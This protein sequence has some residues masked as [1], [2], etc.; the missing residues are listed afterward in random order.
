MSKDPAVI[1]MAMLGQ[2]GKCYNRFHEKNF[3]SFVIQNFFMFK[4]GSAK[5][6]QAVWTNT[7]ISN[8]CDLERLDKGV[9]EDPHTDAPPAEKK[10]QSQ[11]PFPKGLILCQ[12]SSEA[13]SGEQLERVWEI[14]F[15]EASWHPQCC[16]QLWQ[17]QKCSKSPW[18]SSEREKRNLTTAVW[19]FF[20]TVWIFDLHLRSESK[21]FEAALNSEE[22]GEEKIAIGENVNKVQWG[23]MWEFVLIL[24]L[25]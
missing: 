9:E 23:L 10:V 6:T 8:L 22:G 11:F 16:R 17:S 3:F 21:H 12:I 15:E 14:R 1:V 7:D 4:W 25:Q 2:I 20:K 18:S 19:I 13:W 24:Y 5:Y